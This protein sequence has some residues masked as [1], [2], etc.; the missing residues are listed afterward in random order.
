M[1]EE[2]PIKPMFSETRMQQWREAARAFNENRRARA[3]LDP[4]NRFESLEDAAKARMEQIVK[5]EGLR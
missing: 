4:E 1:S 3:I 2:P 5:L